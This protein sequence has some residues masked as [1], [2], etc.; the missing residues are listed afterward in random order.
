MMEMGESS[1]RGRGT[2]PRPPLLF[3]FFFFKTPFEYFFF[4][5]A[6]KGTSGSFFLFSISKQSPRYARA[7]SLSLRRPHFRPRSYTIFLPTRREMSTRVA[8]VRSRDEAER[9]G[10]RPYEARARRAGSD[11]GRPDGGGGGGGGV[12]SGR[13]RGWVRGRGGAPGRRGAGRGRRLEAL[14]HGANR[15]RRGASY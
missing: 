6:D 1:P 5:S 8:A 4:I 9:R 10:R 12:S 2:R 13:R 3:P 7:I 15:R 11:R 14:C